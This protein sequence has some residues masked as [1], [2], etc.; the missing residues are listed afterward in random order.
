VIWKR[1]GGAAGWIAGWVAGWVVGWVVGWVA[2]W[3]ASWVACWVGGTPGDALLVTTETMLPYLFYMGSRLSF[4]L[5][6]QVTG[7]LVYAV[8]DSLLLE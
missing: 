2:S 3:V 8:F 6:H 1:T 5:Y 4:V 7:L